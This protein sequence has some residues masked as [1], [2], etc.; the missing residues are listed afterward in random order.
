MSTYAYVKITVLYISQMD[1][2]FGIVISIFSQKI[3]LSLIHVCIFKTFLETYA[4]WK[5]RIEPGS[6]P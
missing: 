2:N 1:R 3:N 4:A 6:E 5:V